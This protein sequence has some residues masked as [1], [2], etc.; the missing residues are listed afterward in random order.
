MP[1]AFYFPEI[2]LVSLMFYGY[3]KDVGTTITGWLFT[4]KGTMVTL[5]CYSVVT[6][7]FLGILIVYISTATD[8]SDYTQIPYEDE[9]EDKSEERKSEKVQFLKS[10]VTRD[11]C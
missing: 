9:S 8:L 4:S 6:A 2:A 11:N 7:L 3:G 1:L 5:C 10:D